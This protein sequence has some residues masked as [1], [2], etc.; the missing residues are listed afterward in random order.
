M[1]GLEASEFVVLHFFAAL[2]VVE[3]IHK[4]VEQQDENVALF[5]QLPA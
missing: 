1:K 5:P 3:F 4:D 2:D